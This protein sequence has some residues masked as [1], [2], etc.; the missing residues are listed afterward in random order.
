MIYTHGDGPTCFRAPTPVAPA[1]LTN[2]LRPEFLE[3]YEAHHGTTRDSCED[4]GYCECE[5]PPIAYL[6]V[7]L[8][9]GSTLRESFRDIERLQDRMREMMMIPGH[10]MRAHP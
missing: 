3:A 1:V 2:G 6:G 8:A 4:C 9:A 5:C 10:L 7:D